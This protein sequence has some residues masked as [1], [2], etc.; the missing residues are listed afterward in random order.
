MFGGL[1]RFSA[2][3]MTFTN[4]SPTQCFPSSRGSSINNLD[5]GLSRGDPLIQSKLSNAEVICQAKSLIGIIIFSKSCIIR[6]FRFP[7]MAVQIIDINQID[8]HSEV[9]WM[10]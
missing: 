5:K 6:L 2:I 4:P 9:C 7:K 1:A 10:I 8:L 3:E